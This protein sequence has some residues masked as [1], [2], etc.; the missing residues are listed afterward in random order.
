MSAHKALKQHVARLFDGAD[1]FL[2]WKGRVG[3]YATLKAW[4]VGPGDE[5]IMPAF[6]CVVV[7][8]AVLY[9]GA[10]PIYVDIE[11]DTLNT[12]QER[13]AAAKSPRT[14]AVICQNTF[15]LSTQVDAIAS[16]AQQHGLLSI[17]DCTHG[18]G[19]SY[20][21]KPNGSYCDAAFFSSQWN[22]PISSGLGGF[23]VS[24]NA[25]LSDKLAGL[26]PAL[27]SPSTKDVA[28]L[29]AQLWARKYLLNDATYWRLLKAY[30]WMSKVGLV[31]GSSS[32]GE[33]SG[34][35]MPE[36]YFK[37]MSNLQARVITREIDRVEQYN[38]QRQLAA[39]AYTQKLAQLGKAH[40]NP[41]LN[42]DHKFLKYPVLVDD[43]EAFFAAAEQAQVELGDWFNSPLHPVQGDLSPWGL[44]IAQHPNAT[45]ISK[46]V[47]NLPTRSNTDRV[48]AFLDQQSDQLL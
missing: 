31:T 18:F 32:G 43:R 5:V 3:L 1:A 29:A 13:I 19:G 28:N 15:G 37:G 4:G 35:D 24:H 27:A 39:K 44:D 8:N 11:R 42:T 47:V 38:T 6:T 9:L 26:E 23:V 41:A 48:L 40:V 45:Y 30:R 12:T 33:I 17:E 20:G 22:K 36:A 25:N 10:M 14:K 16:W 46:H 34:T 21:G 2:Y 7:P